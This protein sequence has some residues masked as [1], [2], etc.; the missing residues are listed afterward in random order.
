MG[1]PNKAM[2]GTFKLK[3]YKIIVNKNNG[4]PRGEVIHE[5]FTPQAAEVMAK[6]ITHKGEYYLVIPL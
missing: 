6:K 2:V 1:D 3:K 5:A 4:E